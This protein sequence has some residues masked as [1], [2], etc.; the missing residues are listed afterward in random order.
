MRGV[1]RTR[2]GRWAG[3]LAMLAA[4]GVLGAL[5][6]C[7]SKGNTSSKP[8][9]IATTTMIAD[10]ARVVGGHDIEVVSIM[11]E[12]EDPHSY[13]V[14]PR[15]ATRIADAD[16]V[17]MNGLHLEA[18]LGSIVDNNAGDRVARLAEHPGVE[19]IRP[20]GGAGAAPDPHCWM[21]VQLF[22]RYVE[23]I[24]DA[25][26]EMD[27]KHAEGYK[28][29]AAAY[30]AELEMLDTWVREQIATIPAERR[31]MISSHDAF[32]Y[33]GRAYGIEVHGVAGISTDGQVQARHIGELEDLV[34]Q[35]GIPA[36]FGETSVRDALNN[37]INQ[38]AANTDA[39]VS[40]AKLFSDSL[41]AQGTPGG[42]YIGMIRHNTATIV[43]ALRGDE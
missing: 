1:F 12:G 33:Y 38:I 11:R 26:V 15:D 19:P 21:D 14:K 16:L 22:M 25:L 32:G 4:A 20:A 7:G 35:R 2:F 41:G 8:E 28:D 37:Q 40:E 18:T 23:G 39:V 30:L 5:P 6:G 31:V 10:A 42:T 29:R 36:V 34:R 24:R 27:P 13:K 9:V 3:A 43:E 17:L